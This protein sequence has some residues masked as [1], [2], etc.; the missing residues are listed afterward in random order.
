MRVWG[1]VDVREER[2]VVFL[3][4]LHK[5]GR[6]KHNVQQ[7]NKSLNNLSVKAVNSTRSTIFCFGIFEL[8]VF[9]S[10][11][12]KNLP[13]GPPKVESPKYHWINVRQFYSMEVLKIC[14][15]IRWQLRTEMPPGQS[16]CSLGK[17]KG[18][19]SLN[20]MKFNFQINVLY[21]H[22]VLYVFDRLTFLTVWSQCKNVKWSVSLSY[23]THEVWAK[24]WSIS[25]IYYLSHSNPLQDHFDLL[26]MSFS[27]AASLNKLHLK[28]FSELLSF[29]N[30]L[31]LWTLNELMISSRG[32]YNDRF[33]N[34]DSRSPTCGGVTFFHV[35]ETQ[36][37]KR[38]AM[39]LLFDFADLQLNWS[40]GALTP[41]SDRKTSCIK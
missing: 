13:E 12:S 26:L 2:Q 6:H 3:I 16:V 22:F 41:V 29:T 7:E 23:V 24:Q 25:Q 40:V 37:D 4:L 36:I 31:N 14:T 8:V 21:K 1:E 38:Q 5:C 34:R 39:N 10:L 27:S 15:H 33:K 30:R 11:V 9:D 19:M 35:T 17:F 32:C 20:K 28:S 18:K